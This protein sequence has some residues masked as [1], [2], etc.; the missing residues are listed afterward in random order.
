MDVTAVC[1]AIHDWTIAQMPDGAA[2]LDQL[3]CDGKK[4]RGLIELTTGGGS[5]FIAQITITS[6][7]LGV[8]IAL[9]CYATGP[10]IPSRCGP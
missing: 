6:E 4:L 3:V 9:A 2:V 7:A 5:A 10:S 8:A 1:E